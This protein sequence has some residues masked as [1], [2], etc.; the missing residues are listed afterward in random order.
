MFFFYYCSI[1]FYKQFFLFYNDND[2]QLIYFKNMLF[3]NKIILLFLSKFSSRVFVKSLFIFL[4]DDLK[5]DYLQNIN[6]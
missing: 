2:S 3:I 4:N 6:K 1:F 5:K